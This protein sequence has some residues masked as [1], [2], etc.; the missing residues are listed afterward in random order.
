MNDVPTVQGKSTREEQQRLGQSWAARR[1]RYRVGPGSSRSSVAEESVS[2]QTFCSEGSDGRHLR[3]GKRSSREASLWQ[4]AG[5][6][7][8]K[9]RRERQVVR[10]IMSETFFLFF[11]SMQISGHEQSVVRNLF[12]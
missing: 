7:Q 4:Q 2:M 3:R 8:N 11:F 12:S 6:A 10:L 1:C 9:S 5:R